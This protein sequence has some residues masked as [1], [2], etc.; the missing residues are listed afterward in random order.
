MVARPEGAAP[1]PTSGNLTSG[2]ATTVIAVLGIA[3]T[4]VH[5]VAQWN[6]ASGLAAITQVLLMPLVAAWLWSRT[7]PGPRSRLTVLVLLALGFS[8]LGDAVPRVLSGDVGFLAM[9][10]FFLVAQ[11]IYS[12]AFWPSRRASAWGRAP[13]TLVLYGAVLVGVV[14][15]CAKEAGALL[16]AVAVYAAVLA[17]ASVLAWGLGPVAGVGGI[18]FLASDAMIALGAFAPS[19]DPPQR[20]FLVMLTYVAAQ[21]LLAHACARR[22]RAT[23]RDEPRTAPALAGEPG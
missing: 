21:V 11:V 15:L 20:G 10:G 18:I 7:T 23:V 17:T 3:V 2:N 9:I 14:V 13:W 12:A 22:E 6:D 1:A 16:P 4:G 19:F 8:W 5:L